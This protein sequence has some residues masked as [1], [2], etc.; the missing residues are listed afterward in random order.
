M[1]ALWLQRIQLWWKNH[2]LGNVFYDLAAPITADICLL[3]FV[4]VNSVEQWLGRRSFLVFVLM[5]LAFY[6]GGSTVG[7]HLELVLLGLLYA[8]AWTA[9]TFVIVCCQAWIED[10]KPIYSSV[11]TRGIGAVY[12]FVTFFLSSIIWSRVPRLRLA[13][14]VGMF[15]QTWAITGSVSEI[16]SRNFTDIFYPLLV[17][18]V[19]SA[20]SNLLFPRTAHGIYFRA[21]SAALK[22]VSEA[23]DT[24]TSD[25]RQGLQ[26]W[27]AQTMRQEAQTYVHINQS[28]TLLFQVN[29]L[30]K[31]IRAMR[32][33]VAAAQ[34]EI[35]WCRVHVNETAQFTPYLVHALTW[36]RSG[37]GMALPSVFFEEELFDMAASTDDE[38]A[39]EASS[40]L[41][42]ASQPSDQWA[43]QHS[44][45][46]SAKQSLSSLET[47]LRDSITMLL[48]M[49]D[50][51]TG[52]VP[53]IR[54]EASRQFAEALNMGK[55]S[56][57]RLNDA[58]TLIKDIQD[59]LDR[60]METSHAS[61][62][63]L[64]RSRGFREYMPSFSADESVHLATPVPSH[65]YTPS[66]ATEPSESFRE[67]S[68]FTPEM[69]VLAQFAVSLLQLAHQ[70]KN[71]WQ[72]SQSTV[73]LLMERR[74]ASLHFPG[75]NFWQ[76]INSSS[77]IGLF[78]ASLFTDNLFPVLLMQQRRDGDSDT[79][80]LSEEAKEN[81][82][83]NLFE[84]NEPQSHYKYYVANVTN[85]S[86]QAHRTREETWLGKRIKE[87][88]SR[89]SRSPSVLHARMWL[90]LF[91]K[92]LKHSHHFQF[93][94]KLAGGVTLFCM[95]AFLQPSPDDWWLSENGQWM[96]I[97]YIW[98]LEASTGD[99]LRISLCRL[100]GTILGAVCGLI[101][102]EISRANVYALSVLIVCFE[103]P[104]SLLRMY[105][106]YP[107][108]GTVMGLTTPIVAIIPYLESRW[109]S[110]HVA[111]VRGYM[112]ILGIL[113]ALF[114]NTLFW[115]YHARTRLLKK[116]AN[117]TTLLQGFY[118]SL[119]RQMFYG[120]FGLSPGTA[121]HFQR[122]ETDIQ[123]HLT[124]CDALKTIMA[125]EI[126]LVPKPLA[127]IDRI[128]QRLQMIFVLFVVLRL[129]REMHLAQAHMEALSDV[130]P[131]RQELVS[132]VMLDLWMIG[133]SMITR[134]RMPQFAPSTRRAVDELNAAIAL[135]YHEVIGDEKYSFSQRPRL[136]DGPVLRQRIATGLSANTDPILRTK[137]RSY[138]GTL[139]VLAE[140]SILSHV[141]LSLEAL[142]H[143]LRFMLGE[144]RFVQ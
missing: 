67:P 120:K 88:I 15:A 109:S 30:E 66:N 11:K 105:F 45:I 37:F 40:H 133:Q 127:V 10:G 68:L 35:S 39:C 115:P 91:F 48:V 49:V 17:S 142:L 86:R 94:L 144:L 64:M 38:A 41:P 71:V 83:A 100:V 5:H 97:S 103:I 46:C 80:G 99:S 36:I 84:D 73:M 57:K 9:L 141:A 60:A 34:H 55:S 106:R 118:L 131:Q 2:D 6:P 69:Y 112:I 76:W 90:A 138:A 132:T 65:A 85:A 72:L 50:M 24:A 77:G 21:L 104:A 82:M 20:L 74:K 14:R 43:E 70:T 33:A 78:Q 62:Q 123:Q 124:Q 93:A 111:L 137:S 27:S 107:P 119:S 47:A 126:S 87:S 125:I 79:E 1:K 96:I 4:F 108:I 114:V 13:M 18:A 95:I 59:R 53:S 42:T 130:L 92:S 54:C 139:Y 128:Y 22:A 56:T 63:R 25:F 58:S 31:Q 113:A 12:V 44:D 23:V 136:Y 7:A 129:S 51:S 134:S 98:C 116:L 19:I 117:T 8:S 26:S 122:L 52:K 61:L 16:T 135:S 102:F 110:I 121:T 89:L 29:Y 28:E 101:A 143:L 140:H 32:G 3:P 81:N 75:I